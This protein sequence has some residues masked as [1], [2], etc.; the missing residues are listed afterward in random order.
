MNW[1]AIVRP[2]NFFFTGNFLSGEPLPP[3]AV[4]DRVGFVLSSRFRLFGKVSEAVKEKCVI[5]F[6]DGKRVT[7]K[8]VAMKEYFVSTWQLA[9]RTTISEFCDSVRTSPIDIDLR[10]ARSRS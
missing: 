3:V 9:E 10:H 4:G 2:P 1:L 6:D 7:L 8:Q 5:A